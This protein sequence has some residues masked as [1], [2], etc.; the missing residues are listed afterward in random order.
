MWNN[1][2]YCDIS[3]FHKTKKRHEKTYSHLSS[4]TKFKTFGKTRIDLQLNE[5]KNF[6]VLKHNAEVDSNRELMRRLID[7]CCFFAKQEL[8]FR[9]HNE[10]EDSLNR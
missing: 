8:S 5:Q 3:N 7:V 6:D 9:G 2:G 10:R 1:N 4:I